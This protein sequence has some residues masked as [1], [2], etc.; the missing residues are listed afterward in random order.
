MEDVSGM[1]IAQIIRMT[2]RI[3][4]MALMDESEPDLSGQRWEILMRLLVEEKR[5]NGSGVNPTFISRYRNVSK[6]TI[7]SLLRGLEEKGLILRE[8]DPNDKRCFHIKLTKEGRRIAEEGT[9]KKLQKLNQL[10]SGLTAAEKEQLIQLLGKL[11]KTIILKEKMFP[12]FIRGAYE[13]E[14]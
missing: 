13:E 6:N 14:D 7:S 5:G 11:N 3:Y 12:K 2:S 10:A 4:K 1:E 8:L 9:P